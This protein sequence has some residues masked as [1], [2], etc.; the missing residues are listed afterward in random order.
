MMRRIVQFIAVSS[1][2]ALSAGLG[3]CATTEPSLPPLPPAM[4]WVVN[5]EGAPIG[6][7]S[8]TE[9]PRGVLIR[10][11]LNSGALPEGWH[12]VHIHAIG[13]CSD[14]TSGFQA[15]ASHV[16]HTDETGAHGLMN[17]VGPEDGD[18]PNLYAPA[19]GNFGAEFF[20]QRLTLTDAD[21]GRGRILDA[22]GSALIIHAGPDDHETQPIGGAGARLACAAFTVMP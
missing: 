15:S 20:S 19:T 3:A 18:L 10:L 11:E 9:A 8:I 2:L 22:D 6:R 14:V 7:A 5:T 4:S 21:N 17:T 12:G 16:G 1:M 13:N